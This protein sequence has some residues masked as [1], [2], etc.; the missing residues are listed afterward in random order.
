MP[1]ILVLDDEKNIRLT[2]RR[3]L[4]TLEMSVD[5]AIDGEEALAKL[6]ETHYDLLLLDIKLPGMDG[7]EVLK[8]VRNSYPALRVIII[9]AHGSIQTAV[10]AMRQGAVNYLEKPFTPDELRQ[11][12]NKALQ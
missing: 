9:S 6:R 8:I 12:V 11:V 2:V 7:M 5:D 4:E 3:C 10:E 1:Q